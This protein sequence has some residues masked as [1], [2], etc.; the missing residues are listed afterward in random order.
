MS[1]RNDLRFSRRER[2]KNEKLARITEAARHLFATSSVNDV[3]TADVAER[4]DVA[5]GTLFLYAKTKGDLLLMAQN[6]D[7]EDALEEG[8]TQSVLEGEVHKAIESLWKPIFVCNR[9]H[10]E[11]GRAYLREVM[12]GGLG[13]PNHDQALRLMKETEDATANLLLRLLQMTEAEAKGRAS[14]I[15]ALAFVVLSSPAYLNREVESL[16]DLFTHQ[17]ELAIR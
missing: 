10:V 4:A 11:N 3:T 8:I 6:A 14:N 15:S 16:L 7:Y 2:N 17:A 1:I 5:A 13:G 9:K 12:F